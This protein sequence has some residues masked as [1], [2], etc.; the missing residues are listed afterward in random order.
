MAVGWIGEADRAT[1]LTVCVCV[2]VVVSHSG[3]V[4]QCV[5]VW[6]VGGRP[7]GKLLQAVPSAVKN[8]EWNLA[9]FDADKAMRKEDEAIHNVEE[10]VRAGCLIQRNEAGSVVTLCRASLE[11][12]D[13]EG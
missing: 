1:G 12:Y 10:M 9:S 6:S 7:F 11:A 3:G 5:K 4:D 13:T 8:R 2:S